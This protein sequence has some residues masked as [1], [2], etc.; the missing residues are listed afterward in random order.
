MRFMIFI[1]ITFFIFTS[2]CKAQ[3]IKVSYKNISKCIESCVSKREILNK[4]IDDNGDF[5]LKLGAYLNCSSP[6]NPAAE[7][8]FNTD[9]LVIIIPE[10]IVYRDTTFTIENDSTWT[11]QINEEIID[12]YCSC[13]F[14]ISLQI[15]GL[16]T[17]PK[18]FFLNGLIIE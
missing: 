3:D 14:H 11:E 13:F 5:N 9:T 4:S 15:S 18:Y 6:G 7:A 1:S 8:Q 10:Y 2:I 16:S 17:E 12:T